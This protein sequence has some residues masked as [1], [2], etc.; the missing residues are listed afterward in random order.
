MQS[1]GSAYAVKLLAGQV[2]QGG[3]DSLKVAIA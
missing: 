1:D 2:A 3:D